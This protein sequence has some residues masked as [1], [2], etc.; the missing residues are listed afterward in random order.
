[1]EQF[2]DQQIILHQLKLIL[3]K[4]R[5]ELNGDAVAVTIRLKFLSSVSYILNFSS[6][7]FCETIY[8]NM[9]SSI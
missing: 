8:E 1:M 2:F 5:T 4:A 3:K 6:H 9:K 7:E